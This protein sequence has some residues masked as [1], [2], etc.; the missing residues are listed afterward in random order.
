MERRRLEALLT[1][2]A[3]L[4]VDEAEAVLLRA[5]SSA[6][7]RIAALAVV[8]LAR[9]GVAVPAERMSL[10]GRDPEARGI[11]LDGLGALGR[12]FAIPEEHMHV[13]AVAEAELIRWLAS[14]TQM[15]VAPDEVE[16]RGTVPCPPEWGH[17][18]LHVFGFRVRPPHWSADRDW[19]V[20]AVGPFV[21]GA[22]F[23]PRRADGFAA[24]SLYLAEAG[25]GLDGHVLAIAD[26][27]LECRRDE[28]A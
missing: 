16:H 10:L 18:I 26:A 2:F 15:G 5:L 12:H 1:L 8:C 28:A 7:P 14:E 4:P 17:G 9:R 20:G 6:D 23:V 11:L 27:V 25:N 22:E 21:P 24:H 3:H 13:V 19:M